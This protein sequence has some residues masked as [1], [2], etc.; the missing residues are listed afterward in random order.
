MNVLEHLDA[1]TLRE[2]AAVV[3]RRDPLRITRSRLTEEGVELLADILLSGTVPTIG[4]YRRNCRPDGNRPHA[5]HVAARGS[6]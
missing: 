4:F 1:Q 2:L 3:E 6:G 5:R